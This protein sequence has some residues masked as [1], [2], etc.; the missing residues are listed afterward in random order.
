MRCENL[1][2]FKKVVD[3]KF[4]NGVGVKP[5]PHQGDCLTKI[6]LAL[7]IYKIFRRFEKSVNWYRCKGCIFVYHIHIIYFNLEGY[8]N[9]VRD[10]L[11][12][13]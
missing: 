13:Y 9:H 3:Q 6:C 7:S 5:I 2:K 1:V 8:P 4:K 11:D 10:V 12:S